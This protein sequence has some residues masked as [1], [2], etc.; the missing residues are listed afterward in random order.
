MN[1]NDEDNG[2][3]VNHSLADE[4]LEAFWSVIV[5]HY[6]EARSGDLSPASTI[7]LQNA[8]ESAIEEWIA[9]NVPSKPK[10]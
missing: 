5:K 6:P 9:S 2:T 1:M 7:G 10:E 4:A 3:V 8:A